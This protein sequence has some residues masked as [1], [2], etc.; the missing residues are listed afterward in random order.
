M[1]KQQHHPKTLSA[2]GTGVFQA[3]K[4]HQDAL[5]SLS[6]LQWQCRG[7]PGPLMQVRELQKDSDNIVSALGSPDHLNRGGVTHDTWLL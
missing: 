1:Q 4:S 3:W 2:G 5:S 6:G 7:G